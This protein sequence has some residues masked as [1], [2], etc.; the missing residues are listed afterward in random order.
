MH[1]FMQDAPQFILQL[2][3]LAKRPPTSKTQNDYI[4]TGEWRLSN[5]S[6]QGCYS[7]SNQFLFFFFQ[8][9]VVIQVVSSLSSLISLSWSLMSY[10]RVLRYATPDK[11]QLSVGGASSLFFWHTFQVTARVIA[12]ALFATAYKQHVFVL[13]VA[14][15]TLMTSWILAQ[16]TRT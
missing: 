10:Q 8:I 12:L 2:Y 1:S 4:L 15:W 5:D 13:I 3:I 16:V 9:V 6:H 7:E 14:H 11:P